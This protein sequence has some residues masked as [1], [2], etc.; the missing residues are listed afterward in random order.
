M[1]LPDWSSSTRKL[2]ALF[3][4]HL[5]STLV[6]FCAN[7]RSLLWTPKRHSKP[8]PTKLKTL[9]S[10][11]EMLSWVLGC[12]D[13]NVDEDVE[14][15]KVRPA[16]AASAAATGSWPYPKLKVLHLKSGL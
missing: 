13:R 12:D 10:E 4:P 1:T 2:D 6:V 8:S 5:W 9:L 14:I 3:T 11:L 16:T 7:Q 15:L